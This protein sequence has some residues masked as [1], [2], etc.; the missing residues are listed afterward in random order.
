[1]KKIYVLS[2]S[3]LIAV[4]LNIN[5]VVKAQ[6][7]ANINNGLNGESIVSIDDFDWGTVS[8]TSGGLYSRIN[9]SNSLAGVTYEYIWA[10]PKPN[11]IV[12]ISV[13]T[14]GVENEIDRVIGHNKSDH[15]LV[16]L[17]D[18]GDVYKLY[19]NYDL[20]ALYGVTVDSVRYWQN[21]SKAGS[22]SYEKIA[23]DA[24]YVLSSSYLY[25]SKDSSTWQVDSAGTGG[26]HIY[27]FALDSLQ[28]VY[29]AT[30]NGLFK[31]DTGAT[32]F[33]N[34]ATY[35][36]PKDIYRVFIDRHNRLL[37]GL[38]A[39]GVY[40]SNGG[41]VWSIDTAGIGNQFVRLFGDDA[42]GNLYAVASDPFAGIDHLYKSAGGSQP[43]RL[44]DSSIYNKTV[45]PIGISSLSGD[46]ALR[47]GTQ[48]GMFFSADTGKTW[49][50]DNGGIAAKNMFS[51]AKTSTGKLLLSDATGIYG[52]N[53]GD[54]IW[55]K[56][57]PQPGYESGLNLFQNGFGD[58]YTI[59]NAV[60]T[61]YKIGLIEKST[62]GG[63]TWQADTAG[64]SG[65]GGTVFY[66]DE[67]GAQHIGNSQYGSSFLCQVWAKP[68][69]GAWALD[70]V[71]FPVKN[72]SS[73]S[74][75]ASDGKG[76]LYVTGYF[77]R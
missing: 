8:A 69:G 57:Y 61:N 56:S 21:P 47:L 48:F 7:I 5:T 76:Y 36:G 62:D 54:T 63:Q 77:Q 60:K 34:I 10:P 2:A 12:S 26:A 19:L 50:L 17:L 13:K 25:T 27:D 39:G 70:T 72:Y 66:V 52:K 4:L 49:A 37:I 11:K 38:N 55:H 32:A 22:E 29:A 9:I 59:D 1:M 64:L 33:V 24:V 58:I 75:M 14:Y 31:Q 30:D 46:S 6:S 71:G 44:T 67:K 28:R 53:A 35:A 45:N 16:V 51:L 3:I 43:W 41:T 74:A 15:D 42:Y 68:S 73:V 40:K 65:T 23:G 20:R 18:N